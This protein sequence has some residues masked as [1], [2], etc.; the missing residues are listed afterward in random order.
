[1]SLLEK[2]GPALDEVEAAVRGAPLHD[3]LLKAN[4][5]IGELQAEK[6]ARAADE[7]AFAARLAEH[8]A[9]VE[10]VLSPPGETAPIDPQPEEPAA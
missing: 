10:A 4:A 2:F 5:T 7:D 9:V 1:M 6:D 3:A 8:K